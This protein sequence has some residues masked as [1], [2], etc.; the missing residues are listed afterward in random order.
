MGLIVSVYRDN[1]TFDC[2]NDGITNRFNRLCVVN[3]E[4][5]FTPSDDCPAVILVEGPFQQ[6]T[7]KSVHLEPVS[8]QDNVWSMFGGNYASTSDSRLGQ[9]VEK[10]IGRRFF[11][12]IPVHD[13]VE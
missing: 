9:A 10:M 3:A 6:E 13:R 2:T 12:A 5:P 7:L 8:L 4:G 1:S 11:G